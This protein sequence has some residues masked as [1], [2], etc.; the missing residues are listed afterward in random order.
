MVRLVCK[1]CNYK[2]ELEKL[3]HCPYCGNNSLEKE[4]NAKE[5]IEEIEN[6]LRN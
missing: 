3:S 5:L 1:N 6:L 2:C 4:K